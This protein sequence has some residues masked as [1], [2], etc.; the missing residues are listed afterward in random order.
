MVK[1]KELQR[2]KEMLSKGQLSTPDSETGFHHSLYAC[3]PK[4]DEESSINR[5]ERSGLA[6]N[7]VVFRCTICCED[8]DANVDSMFL[9]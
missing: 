4:C 9:K 7:R 8:F 6:I 3:C 1:K 5:V 2:I